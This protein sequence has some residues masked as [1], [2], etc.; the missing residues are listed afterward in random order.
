MAQIPDAVVTLERD[1]RDIFGGRFQ[2]LVV[3]G[4]RAH[5]AGGDDAHHGGA[6]HERALTHTLVVAETLG[7]ADLQACAD[8]LGAWND[9]GLATPLLMA[10]HEFERA[11]DVFPLEFGAI[12]ADH[13][14]AA[15]R[16]PFDG[17]RVDPQDLRRASESQARSHLLH[18]REGYVETR[19]RA[20][21][22]AVL[23]VASAA[24]LARLVTTLA[25]LDGVETHD[26]GAA[27]RHAERATGAAA[28][29]VANIVALEGVSEISS[30]AARQL[31]GPYLEAVDRI[32]A[33]VDGWGKR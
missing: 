31:I 29:A 32:V 2:S 16:D 9:A 5:A 13:A 4:Q 24:P 12:V 17:A 18:L 26:A 15:G 28:G 22:L 33:F 19:G 14:V 3:Y 30:D 7:A 21:A 10:A 25:R 1:V 20:D 8:R 27:A 23:I 6:G 11:L